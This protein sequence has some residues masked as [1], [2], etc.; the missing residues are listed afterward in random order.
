M[1]SINI[2][3]EQKA[4]QSR[5]FSTAKLVFIVLVWYAVYIHLQKAADWITYSLLGLSKTSHIGT[6]SN[7]FIFE[8]PKVLMLLVI[9][10]FGV[11]IIR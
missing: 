11:G 6:A 10:V 4:E 7:F 2:L 9:V 8:V 3:T 5:F 1:A